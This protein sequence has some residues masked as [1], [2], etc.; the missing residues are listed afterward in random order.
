MLSYI[1][2]Y[3]QPI[4]YN[5]KKY[6]NSTVICHIIHSHHYRCSSLGLQTVFF[7]EFL[8]LVFTWLSFSHYKRMLTQIPGQNFVIKPQ[9]V[10]ISIYHQLPAMIKKCIIKLKWLQVLIPAAASLTTSQLLPSWSLETAIHSL[11]IKLLIIAGSRQHRKV[12]CSSQLPITAGWTAAFVKACF[13]ETCQSPI[14][15]FE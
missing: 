6:I 7:C 8:V 2:V 13:K 15:S 11:Q 10:S 4:L 1:P 12:T 14:K 5:Q 3:R 9:C